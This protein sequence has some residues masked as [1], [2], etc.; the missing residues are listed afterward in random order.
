MRVGDWLIF[1]DMGAY[2]TAAGS[3]FNGFDTSEI[4]IYLAYST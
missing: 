4:K 1:D 2:T 3:K